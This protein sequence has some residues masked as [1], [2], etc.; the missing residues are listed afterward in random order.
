MWDQ[1]TMHSVTWSSAGLNE[2]HCIQAIPVLGKEQ[3]E[4][5]WKQNANIR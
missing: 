4:M 2:I 5:E 3:K 1:W